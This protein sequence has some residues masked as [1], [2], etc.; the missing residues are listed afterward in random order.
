METIR[1]NG[2]VWG[3]LNNALTSFR[4]GVMERLPGRD[5]RTDGARADKKHGSTSQHQEDP[6]GTV[7]AW[8]ADVNWLRSNVPHGDA[9]E[10]RL[11]EA[12]RAD[13]MDDPRS[14]LW[15]SDRKIS[16]KNV[17]NG[18]V[19]HYDGESPHTEHV[20]FEA[21]QHLE[22]DGR[23]W[24]MPRTD[25]LLRELRGDDDV[26]P[27]EMNQIADLVV[28][29]LLKADRI[30]GYKIDGTAIAPVPGKPAE[31]TLTVG[32]AL[33]AARRAERML[34]GQVDAVSR[35]LDR[36]IELLSGGAR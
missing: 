15:I 5:T 30:Q 35:K 2:T 24:A 19:R 26:T 4:N 10:D 20:H 29:K 3:G 31:H 12:I 7:D 28:D 32:S 22:D 16:N 23:P 17:Q 33:A 25:A 9:N 14:R 8:D 21:I 18:K 36:V 1:T 6:D 11:T 27:A 13:F 34:P